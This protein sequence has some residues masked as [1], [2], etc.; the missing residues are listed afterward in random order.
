MFSDIIFGKEHL[1]MLRRMHSS[2][3]VTISTD[4]QCQHINIAS[5]LEVLVSTSGKGS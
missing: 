2:N 1:H 3:F 5:P 4:P